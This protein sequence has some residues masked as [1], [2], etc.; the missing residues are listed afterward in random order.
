[1]HNP[2]RTENQWVEVQSIHQSPDSESDSSSG[3]A[4]PVG[5]NSTRVQSPELYSGTGGDPLL[6]D[7][8]LGDLHLRS[9]HDNPG[10]QLDPGAVDATT[11]AVDH[12]HL[13]AQ[14]REQESDKRKR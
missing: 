14:L 2:Q 6:L 13:D 1:M 4:T 11:D 10:A 7:E 5:P 8:S 9:S 3:T 12:S